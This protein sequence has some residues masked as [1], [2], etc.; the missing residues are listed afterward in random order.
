MGRDVEAVIEALKIALEEARNANDE[1]WW[2]VDAANRWINRLPGAWTGRWRDLKL[3]GDSGG[4]VDRNEFIGHLRATLAY[5][6]A[7]R[8]AI[9]RAWSWSKHRRPAKQNE[10]PI[11]ADFDDVAPSK[12]KLP[13][14][15]KA[16][17]LIK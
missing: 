2:K 17:R 1:T 7:N 8:E 5:L 13:R 11:D 3:K 10:D 16:V 14:T 12:A 15:G 4:D 6:E 9:A